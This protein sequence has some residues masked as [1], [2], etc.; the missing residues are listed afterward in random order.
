MKPRKS[1]RNHLPARIFSS[2]LVLTLVFLTGTSTVCAES[3][4]ASKSSGIPAASA[5]S[6]IS[7]ASKDSG[8]SS[9]SA[10][11]SSSAQADGKIL[12][13]HTNDVHC[14]VDQTKDSSGNVTGLGYAALAS[15]KK[16]MTAEYGAE[17]VTLLDAG[18]SI[19]G[20]SIGTLSSGSW[21]INIMNRVG[22]D[23]AVPG[24]HEFDF[25]I[26]Q[27]LNLTKMASFPYLSCNLTTKAD[28]KRILDAYKI[29]SYGNT[30]IAYVGISTPES[31]TKST[32]AYFQDE[33][34]NYLYSFAEDSDGSSLYRAV[35]TAV[36]SAKAEGPIM[37]SLSDIWVKRALQTSGP[38]PRSSPIRPES[39]S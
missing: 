5:S 30:K 34:G 16:K 11:E 20:G 7:A 1:E 19:Q 38:V 6:G 13:L 4:S 23:L 18:D 8:T 17:N 27:F 26:S 22:Y 33:N 29:L 25:G 37:S 36:D 9:A 12:L 14:A 28:G 15:Y 2:V 35:Q 39:T 32:P 10:E 3:S 24:N 21:I 31:I